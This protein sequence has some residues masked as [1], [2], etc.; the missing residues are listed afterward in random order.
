MY[1]CPSCGASLF[2]D[3]KTQKLQCPS[4]RNE[5]EPEEIEK[6]KL[7]EAKEQKNNLEN[8]NQNDEYEAISYK[9]SHCGAELLTTDETITTF[10]SFCRMGTMLDRKIIK[11]QKPDYIIPFKISKEECKKIYYNKIKKSFFAPKSM[12]DEQE[13]EKIRGI[14]MPYWIYSFEEN[15]RTIALGEKYSHR[16][17]D[18][19]YYDKYVLGTEIDAKV[20]GTSHDATSNFSD[21]LSEA[22]SPFSIKDKKDF[23]PSYLSGY[24]ADNEDVDKKIYMEENNNLANKYISKELEKAKEFHKYNAKPNVELKKNKAELALFPI[25]FLATKNKR[26]DRISYAVINGQTGKIAADIPIDFGKFTIF[27][28][29][30]AVILFFVLNLFLTPTMPILVGCSVI[31]N[32]ICC[33]IL[34][35][36]NKE[37]KNRENDLSDKGAKFKMEKDKNQK[38]NKSTKNMSFTDLSFIKPLVALIITISM[39]IINPPQDM[40]YYVAALISIGIAILSFYNIIAK[41]NILTTRKLP[42]LERRGGDENA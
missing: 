23:S 27:S 2:F 1:L 5:Y 38:S 22:I 24:Y 10:C 33:S 26:E 30:L 39:F 42:Q 4:C 41:L 32:I 28:L 35:I 21:S 8:D 19:V 18:Y 17:G 15:G 16:S 11:K 3:P 36:Q 14:Y 40:Y 9:C 12:I 31:F 6:A 13:V 25:Y 37:I 29:F 34:L 7:D 20:Y